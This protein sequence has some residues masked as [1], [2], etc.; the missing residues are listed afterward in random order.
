M[1]AGFLG[2]IFFC[3]GKCAIF[4]GVLRKV[5]L[6]VMGFCGDVVVNCW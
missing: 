2:A 1:G 6:I 3:V 4:K 5:V